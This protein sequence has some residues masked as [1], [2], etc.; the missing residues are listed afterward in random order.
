M[1]L[2]ASYMMAKEVFVLTGSTKLHQKNGYINHQ[3]EEQAQNTERVYSLFHYICDARQLFFPLIHKYWG[4]IKV[5][6][7]RAP[8]LA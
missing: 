1:S 3:E 8:F 2:N 6:A 5:K 7:G 4:C